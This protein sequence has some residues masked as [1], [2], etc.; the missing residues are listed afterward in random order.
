MAKYVRV[1]SFLGMLGVLFLWV[2]AWAFDE[3]T[4][5]LPEVYMSRTGGVHVSIPPWT[6]MC[7][8]AI[9]F[10]ISSAPKRAEAK[11]RR[12]AV[13]RRCP[14]CGYCLRGLSCGKCPECGI[15]IT[16]SRRA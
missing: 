8:F 15:P 14:G 6:I 10:W 9:A 2:V 1:I 4:M 12:M 3:K 5:F 13:E 16:V 11:R 7:A